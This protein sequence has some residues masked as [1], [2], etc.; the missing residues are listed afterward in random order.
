MLSR[1]PI[2]EPSVVE[3][4]AVM[5]GAKGVTVGLVDATGR[6]FTLWLGK[7]EASL[8]AAMLAAGPAAV[9][10]MAAVAA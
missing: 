5:S 9:Q 10:G 6:N 1:S 3:P 8:L 4:L 7:P 2:P